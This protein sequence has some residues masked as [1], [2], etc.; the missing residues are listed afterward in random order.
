[1]KNNQD[2]NI[3]LPKGVELE[4]NE[5]LVV[6]VRQHWFVFRD[7][8]LLMTFVPF[9][10][11]SAVFFAE[12]FLPPSSVVNALRMLLLYAAGVSMVVGTV[13]FLWR[14]YLWKRTVYLL[15]DKRIIII[16][17]LGLFTHDDRE[18]GLTM[19]QDVRS[20]V[21]GLQATLYGYGDVI[22]QVSSKDAQ[23]ILEKVGH[24]REVQR[25]IIKEAHLKDKS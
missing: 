16:R 7:S 25:A 4:S 8:V 11:L 6:M 22:I 10:L 23:L 1:M 20:K 13:L 9:V 14:Y 15:T 5:V 17:Q 2:N 12:Y 18:T 3:K 21:D 24:S 19:I